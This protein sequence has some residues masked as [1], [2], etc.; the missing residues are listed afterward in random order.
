[1]A[2]GK[3]SNSEKILNCVGQA[4]NCGKGAKIQ[5]IFPVAKWHVWCYVNWRFSPGLQQY[6]VESESHGISNFRTLHTDRM[7]CF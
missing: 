7:C 3:C 4:N 5:R 2:C 1:M 6:P